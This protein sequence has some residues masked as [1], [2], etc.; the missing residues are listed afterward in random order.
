M[1]SLLGRSQAR[2]KTTRY[3]GALEDAKKAAG[4]GH[5]HEIIKFPPKCV[6][7]FGHWKDPIY[8]KKNIILL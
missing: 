5:I 7:N 6:D 2:A 3:V 8:L 1:Q 4:N